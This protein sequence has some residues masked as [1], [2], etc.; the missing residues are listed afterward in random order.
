MGYDQFLREAAPFFG[1]QWRE[2]RRRGVRRKVERR[3]AEIGLPGF[4]EYLSRIRE[5]QEEQRQ[6]S[7]ILTVTISRFFRDKEVFDAIEAPLLPSILK[8]NS[9]G[10]LKI[11][12]IGCASGEEPFSLS[13][14]WKERFEKRWT[15]ARFRILAT[16]INEYLLDRAKER[17]YKKSSLEEIPEEIF[18]HFFK[19]EGGFFLIN[20]TILRTV[21]FRRHDIIRE[22]PFTGMDLVLC[23]NLAFTYFSK[24]CQ[25][26]VLRKIASSL[27]EDG[28]LVIGKDESLPLTYPTLFILVFPA[29]KIYRKF[30]NTVRGSP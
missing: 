8:N 20:Q 28:H 16:D 1:L 22:E 21:E 27:K 9:G 3:I 30:T 25:I 18:N 14:L 13:L 4:E 11:W 10:D 26:E 2:F 5:D 23:R 6:L 17:M 24:E 12:S 15:R 7:Q 29:E 19:R